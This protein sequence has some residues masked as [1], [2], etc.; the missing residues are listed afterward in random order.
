M[1]A[2]SFVWEYHL[3]FR[4]FG[5]QSSEA[6]GYEVDTLGC[7]MRTSRFSW[8]LSALDDLLENSSTRLFLRYVTT[9]SFVFDH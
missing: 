2:T 3:I 6:V 9:S 5:Y 8:W 4:G 7:G 1:E